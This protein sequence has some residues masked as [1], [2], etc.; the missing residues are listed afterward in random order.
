MHQKSERGQAIVVIA[1]SL[2]VL[3]GFAALAIDGGMVYADRREIKNV[4]DAAALSGG[5]IAALSL[6]NSFVYFSDFNEQD[7][8]IIVNAVLDQYLQ[9]KGKEDDDTKDKIFNQLDLERKYELACI[10]L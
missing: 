4:A 2:V 5:G 9:Y 6:D 7:A 8:Q 3:L 1:V 10:L